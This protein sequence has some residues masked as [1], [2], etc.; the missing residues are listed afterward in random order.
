MAKNI[1][2]VDKQEIINLVE[3]AKPP[4]DYHESSGALFYRNYLGE[5]LHPSGKY[6]SNIARRKYYHPQERKQHLAAGH[7]VGYRWVIQNYTVEEGWVL[8]PTCG[9]GTAMVESYNNRRNSLG[10]DL[11]F[12]NVALQ[13]AAYQVERGQQQNIKFHILSSSFLS[14][15]LVLPKDFKADLVINGP[16]YPI[17]RG[18]NLSSDI[19]ESTWERN[20]QYSWKENLGMMR[21]SDHYWRNLKE[22]Y[23]KCKKLLS[24]GGYFCTI[25]KDPI[26]EKKYYPLSEKVGT[27]LLSLGFEIEGSFLH[28]HIPSTLFMHTYPKKFPNV[29]MP[30]YQTGMIYRKPL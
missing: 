28:R 19:H 11:E 12:A 23:L 4:S 26:R 6:Y 5:I 21:D 13:N 30:V 15:D 24:P 17:M 20:I 7:W 8:D 14:E 27:L 2:Q 3:C 29:K 1:V 16:P 9:S 18:S 10:V 22:M 25:I